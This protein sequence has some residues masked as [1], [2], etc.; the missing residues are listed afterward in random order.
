MEEVEEKEVEEPP[1]TPS[2]DHSDGDISETGAEVEGYIVKEVATGAKADYQPTPLELTIKYLEADD[3][4]EKVQEECTRKIEELDDQRDEVA[5]TLEEAI[6][7]H[8][9]DWE[10]LEQIRRTGSS[11]SRSVFP[12]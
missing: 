4:L 5:K 2:M 12:L 1:L 3:R 8:Q 10:E 6:T 11:W 7:A 9:R